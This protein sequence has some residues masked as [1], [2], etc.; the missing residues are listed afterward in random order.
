MRAFL[1]CSLLTFFVATAAHSAPIFKTDIPFNSCKG[2]ICMSVQLD[3]GKSATLILDTSDATNVISLEA[4]KSHGW[5]VTP[6]VGKDG[7][8]VPGVFNAGDHTITL[9]SLSQSTHFLAMSAADMGSHGVYD[10][11]LVYLFFKD[12]A[13]QIDYPNRRIR[14]SDILTSSA[15]IGDAPGQLKIVNFHKWG[16]PIVVGAPFTINGKP[17]S[18][19][20]DTSYT[21]TMLIYSAA[22]APLDLGDVAKQGKAEMFPFTDGGVSMLAAPTQSEGFAS[23]RLGAKT[24]LVYFPTA[25][26]HEPENPFEATVGNA[27]FKDSVLT[28]NFHDMTLD[29]Q[30][31]PTSVN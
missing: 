3:D 17:V 20:I 8:V 21:G 24:P 18:A 25:G 19:Q 16:P 12:R 31:Q 4:A 11:N 27:L 26:V 6:Y 1:S 7:K 29:V 14:V 23:L 15:A 9:G 28:L 2:L 22:I 5:N 10:G 30:Q 13:L